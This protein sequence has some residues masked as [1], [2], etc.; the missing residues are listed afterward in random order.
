MEMLDVLVRLHTER[1]IAA[2]I[3][4]FSQARGLSGFSV[5]YQLI[6]LLAAGDHHALFH[7][8]EGA[9][10]D[11]LDRQIRMQLLHRAYGRRGQRR[12]VLFTQWSILVT[13]TAGTH[14]ARTHARSACS[15]HALLSYSGRNSAA[16]TM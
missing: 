13:R 9:Q 15:A 11:D 6:R 7:L 3:L 10:P 8:P 16:A 2:R 4:G 14:A 12:Y 5:E 1:K